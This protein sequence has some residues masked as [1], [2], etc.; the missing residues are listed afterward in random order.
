VSDSEE[1]LFMHKMFPFSLL[2]I[3]VLSSSVLLP[4]EVSA[5]VDPPNATT[6]EVKPLDSA[7]HVYN[8][9]HT[10]FRDALRALDVGWDEQRG[11]CVQRNTVQHIRYWINE[12]QMPSRIRVYDRFNRYYD[13]VGSK[14]VTA[15]VGRLM[16]RIAAEL[17]LQIDR[18]NRHEYYMLMDMLLLSSDQSY[19]GLIPVEIHFRSK[20][21]PQSTF[22]EFVTDRDVAWELYDEAVYPNYAGNPRDLMYRLRHN[23]RHS[24]GLGHTDDQRSVMFPTNVIGLYRTNPVD[25]LAIHVLLCSSQQPRAQPPTKNESPVVAVLRQSA[26]EGSGRVKII[27]PRQQ[28]NVGIQAPNFNFHDPVHLQAE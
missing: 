14:D 28:G 5:G 23:F 7:V 20:P 16:A 12:H 8:V 17:E 13:C 26:P 15:T 21:Y 25:V 24:L 27:K 6:I 18:I 2:P 3:F 4:G 11:R 22:V 10:Y 1:A 9:T 19:Q